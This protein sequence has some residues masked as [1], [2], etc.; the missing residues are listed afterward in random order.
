[1]FHKQFEQA[2]AGMNVGILLRGVEK[3]EVQR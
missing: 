3:D 2:D 1:M